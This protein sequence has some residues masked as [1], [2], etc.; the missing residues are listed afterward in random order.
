MA[1]YEPGY[2]RKPLGAPRLMAARLRLS[3]A[4]P[5]VA[6]DLRGNLRGGLVLIS[7]ETNESQAL[8]TALLEALFYARE[9]FSAQLLRWCFRAVPFTSSRGCVLRQRIPQRASSWFRESL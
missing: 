6:A 7:N 8:N 5:I 2:G 9:R 1:R 3:S 4:S